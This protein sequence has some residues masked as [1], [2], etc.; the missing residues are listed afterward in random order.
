[1]PC[2][3]RRCRASFPVAV[4]LPEPCRPAIRIT[5]GGLLANTRSRPAPPISLV[6]SSSTSFTT[7]WPGLSDW[8]TSAPS[9]R[10]FTAAV[11]CLTTWKLTSASSSARR[12][13]RIALF[14]SS[15]VSL[16]R[17]R[18][19]PRAAWSRSES[20][21]NTVGQASARAASGRSV[22]RRDRLARG[23]ARRHPGA[24]R[25]RGGRAV[26]ARGDRLHRLAEAAKRVR[27]LAGDDPDLVRLPL[28][29]LRQHLQVLVGEQLGVGVP[30]VDRAED[31][32]DRLGL[33][34]RV[35]PLRL[36]LALGA[37]DR[38]LLLALGREDLRLLDALGLEDRGTAVT[39]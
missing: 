16:P 20:V 31:G 14:T 12:I 37:Q 26:A 8:S 21:S 34:L 18:T 29:D 7:C 6:S 9:A 1:M 19:S 39:L 17:E 15:S 22:R 28:R 11:N 27:D 33:A 25:R 30:C 2:S 24:A 23:P 3:S 5:V 13:W 36:A 10:S 38:A 4:V 35:E 32:L